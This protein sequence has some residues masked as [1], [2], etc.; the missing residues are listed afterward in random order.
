M[1]LYNTQKVHYERL[2]EILKMYRIACDTSPTGAGKT[3]VCVKL[4]KSLQIPLV[5]VGPPIVQFNWLKVCA[6]EKVECMFISAYSIKK[7][8]IP[9]T[10]YFLAIDE[11]HMFKNACSRSA[12]LSALIN[13]G[14][15]Q[16]V[17]FISATLFD[18]MRQLVNLARYFQ[19]ID[20][21]S[22]T[23]NMSCNYGVLS[24]FYFY[25]V[26]QSPEEKTMYLSGERSICQSVDPVT[27]NFKPELFSH[28]LRKIHN[29]LIEGLLRYV[30]QCYTHATDKLVVSLKY[31]EHFVAIKARHPNALIMN[32]D[33]P[34]AER[35]AII[36]KFQE[37]NLN[38]RLLC[39]TDTVGGI[40]IDLDDKYGTYPRKLI[41]LPLFATDFLQMI[42]RVNRRSSRSD[43]KVVVIQPW[44]HNSFFVRQLE[45]K[46]PIISQLNS[47]CAVG[48][49]QF[50]RT[51]E[52]MDECIHWYKDTIVGANID[53]I[54][55]DY[56]CTCYETMRGYKPLKK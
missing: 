55:K 14:S 9:F 37:K 54:I 11:G 17:L 45:T 34:S 3:I 56:A 47:A 5:I 41:C 6:L 46:M 12:E 31:K 25:H 15:T 33:T 13:R 30:Q 20:I 22:V 44:G 51:C 26:T 4:A 23:S 19:G 29:S 50:E 8:K 16:Y 7:T 49:N 38:Y 36:D 1:E 18:H 32:G 40:G 35:K 53:Y 2:L 48:L 43:A 24:T 39:V 10:S 42:G 28:G 27:H 52:H 21:F